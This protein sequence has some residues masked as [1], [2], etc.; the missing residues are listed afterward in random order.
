[1]KTVIEACQPRKSIIE[2]TFNPEIFTASLEP[3]ISYYHHVEEKTA[4]DS[5]YTDAKAFFRDATYPTDGLRQVV[6]SVF[7]RV[8]GDAGAPAIYRLET[9]FGGG[10]THTLISCV[11]IA[12][13]GKELK[14]V[15]SNILDE[16]YLPEPGTVDVVGIAGDTLPVQKTSGDSIQPYTIWGDM[17]YQLGG[18]DLYEQVKTE[19]ESY[20]APGLPFFEKVLGDRKAVIM[21]DELAQ[22]ATRLE[23]VLPG[24]G[25]D[26]LSAFL[27]TLNNYAKNH[28]GISVIVTLASSSDAFAHQTKALTKELNQL[29]GSENLT[30]NDA[31]S[32]AQEATKSVSSVVSREATVVT[33]VQA[34]EIAAILAKRLF[35]SIDQMAAREVMQEYSAMYSLSLIHI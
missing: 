5:I 16:K 29:T 19:A 7:R 15:T 3:V 26:M 17:A 30:E 23:V 24:K 9:Q 4:I 11:H 18:K 31:R 12:Y 28:T 14:D 27:M 25:A 35:D 8:R 2:G 1:M 32:L 33:P 10:K 22:Y 13:R 34:N 20:A 21:L 6:S